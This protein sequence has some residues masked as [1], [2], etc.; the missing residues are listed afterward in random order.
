MRKNFANAKTSPM[1]KKFVAD[2][3]A[4]DAIDVFGRQ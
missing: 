3:G 4:V 1:Q 2:D